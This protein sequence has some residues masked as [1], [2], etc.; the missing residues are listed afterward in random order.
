MTLKQILLPFLFI[1]GTCSASIYAQREIPP[2]P[3]EQTAVYDE[4]RMLFPN[5]KQLEQK[6]IRYSD[7]T[8]TQIVVATINSLQ[9]E[10]IGLYAAEWA[11]KWGIGQKKE[12]NGVFILVAK[13]DR[14]IWIATGYGVE[15][16]LTDF[17][18]KTII[19]DIITPE[20]KRNNF[21]GGLDKGTTAIFQVLDGTF[22]GS[23]KKKPN[24]PLGHFVLLFF[25][26]VIIIAAFR[27]SNHKN[28]GKGNRGNRSGSGSLLDVIILS[29]MG[30][31]GFGGGGSFGGGSSGGFGGGFGGGGFG[32]GGAGGS[33]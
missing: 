17:V 14:K 8:S 22:K 1:L 33:W 5:S 13:N 9:G 28:G 27:K 19:D 12:D 11:H 16:K 31:G 10:N 23:R 15:D 26:V 3:K 4:A 32:G 25:I 24:A 20:F 29:N 21:Y 18:S 7:T 30:R 6:L 2:K